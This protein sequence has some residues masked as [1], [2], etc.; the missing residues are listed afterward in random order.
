M[1]R[2]GKAIINIPEKVT[3][4]TDDKGLVTVKGVK[5]LQ[6]VQLTGSISVKVKGSELSVCRG[7]DETKTRT[8]HGLYRSLVFNAVYG[9]STGWSKTL[10]LNGVGYRA[11]ASQKTLDLTLGFSHPIQFLIPSGITIKVEKQTTVTITGANKALVG[12]V[13]ADIRAYRLP[14]PYLGKGIRYSDEVIR[15]KAG[16]SGSK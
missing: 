13:S 2:V 6:T 5:D 12:Q 4:T 8:L 7:D 15:R 11:A 16:K 3:V 1:S 9:V 10:I 14:E